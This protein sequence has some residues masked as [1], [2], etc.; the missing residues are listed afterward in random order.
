MFLIAPVCICAIFFFWYGRG[1]L[2]LIDTALFWPISAYY[3]LDVSIW[4]ALYRL[5]RSAT[6]RVPL[7]IHFRIVQVAIFSLFLVILTF[8]IGVIAARNLE[9]VERCPDFDG[10][11]SVLVE[12]TNDI[13]I[14]AQ[15][16]FEK[17]LVYSNFFYFILPSTGMPKSF[18]LGSFHPNLLRVPIDAGPPQETHK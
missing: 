14:C 15:T 3:I 8:N 17:R 2:D 18:Q 7:D 5:S 16:D 9:E 13:A 12:R 11:Q 10:K 6:F 1:H 4:K